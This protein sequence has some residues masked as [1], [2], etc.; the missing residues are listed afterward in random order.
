MLPVSNSIYTTFFI[1]TFAS[2][3]F[4]FI[5]IQGDLK[6][7]NFI[8]FVIFWLGIQAF[9]TLQGLYYTNTN[10]IPPKIFL[11]GIFPT[12][13]IIT[14]L[15]LSKKG[16]SFIDNLS[17][18]FLTRLHIVRIPVEIALY[19]LYIE[20]KIP[21]L[22]TFEGRNFD[23]IAGVTAP[24]MAY[25]VFRKKVLPNKILLVWNVICL[26][27]LI[28]IVINAILSAPSPFQQFAF[29]QPNIA[30]LYFPI[31]WLPTFIVPIVLFSHLV[32]IRN[33]WNKG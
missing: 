25:L 2:I 13:I 27:L 21:Q 8:L 29:E 24:L 7:R 6:A 3:I 5:S 19:Q 22:M 18:E 4:F 20:Q 14:Y 12:I 15:F 11:F 33:L 16:K 1:A 23:I 17:L 30:I 9:L 32:A 28:N 10:A 31:S 26:G